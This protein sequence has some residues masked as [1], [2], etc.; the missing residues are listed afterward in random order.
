M[1]AE[2]SFLIAAPGFVTLT[3]RQALSVRAVSSNTSTGV[4][5]FEMFAK[6][7]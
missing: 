1:P 4:L 7:E 5:V 6:V 2:F 3:G